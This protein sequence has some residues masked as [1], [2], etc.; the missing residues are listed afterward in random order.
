[1]SKRQRHHE[2][3]TAGM[4]LHFH[5][6]Q[7]SQHQLTQPQRLPL[8]GTAACTRLNNFAS[9]LPYLLGVQI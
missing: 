8:V 6:A 3:A 5:T 4:G 7:T 2:I 9:S 1:M